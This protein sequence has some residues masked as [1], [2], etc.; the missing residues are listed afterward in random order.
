MYYYASV[1]K[2]PAPTLRDLLPVTML[3]GITNEGVRHNHTY[4]GVED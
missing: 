2:E 4:K 3:G 1:P